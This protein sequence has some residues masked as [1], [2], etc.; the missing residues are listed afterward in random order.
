MADPESDNGDEDEEES[1]HSS[2]NSDNV[3][4]EMNSLTLTPMTVRLALTW[5]KLQLRDWL[6]FI[7]KD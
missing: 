5:S 2:A 1:N 3:D 7:L 6:A 4:D